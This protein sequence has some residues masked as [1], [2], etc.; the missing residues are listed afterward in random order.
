[1]RDDSFESNL[2]I[3]EAGGD[4]SMR[5]FVVREEIPKLFEDPAKAP[6]PTPRPGR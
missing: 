3:A 2:E 1:M 5:L 6:A 4:I